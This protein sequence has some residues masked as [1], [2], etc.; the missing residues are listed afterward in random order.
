LF[1]NLLGALDHRQ[2]MLVLVIDGQLV[3]ALAH[4]E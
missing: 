2:V 4:S 3:A 1:A